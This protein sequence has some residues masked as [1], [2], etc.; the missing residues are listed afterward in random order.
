[1]THEQ[2]LIAQICQWGLIGSGAALFFLVLRCIN[3]VRFKSKY[4]WQAI[5]LLGF[6]IAALVG[7]LNYQFNFDWRRTNGLSILWW[8]PALY[9]AGHIVAQDARRLRK[10]IDYE[11]NPKAS[12]LDSIIFDFRKVTAELQTSKT[13]IST[14]L[15]ILASY[16]THLPLPAWIKAKDGRMMAINESY[17]RAYGITLEDYNANYDAKSWGEAVATDFKKHDDIVLATHEEVFAYEQI[18]N[19]ITRTIQRLEVVKFPIWDNGDVIAIA[20]LVKG[21][22]A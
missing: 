17:T 1:M 14:P 19:P 10:E 8:Y 3:R 16:I 4:F 7:M 11:L 15:E 20:G 9:M 2:L 5:F 22:V 13:V 21:Y 12:E 6:A 18:E